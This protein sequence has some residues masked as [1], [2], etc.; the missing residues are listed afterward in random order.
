MANNTKDT[1]DETSGTWIVH[2]RQKLQ[3]DQAGASEFPALDGAAKPVARYWQIELC[4]HALIL[5]VA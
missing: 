4:A 3:A 5:R 1:V 2:H